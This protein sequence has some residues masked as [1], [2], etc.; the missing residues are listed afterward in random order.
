MGVS[1]PRLVHEGLHRVA[2]TVLRRRNREV[3][4]WAL[5]ATR[6]LPRGTFLGFFAGEVSTEAR[7]SLYA[8]TVGHVHIYPFADEARITPAE[9]ARRP[10]ASMNEPAEGDT[11]NCF[12]VV[13]DLLPDEVLGPAGARLYRGLACFTCRDV[14][15]DE[16]LTWHYGA[17]YE[18]HRRRQGYVAGAA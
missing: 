15:R 16:E 13:Q 12:M 11:A 17:S 5:V 10:L 18:P 14:A 6:D 8:A 1:V 3:T 7:E 9:R 2:S 4:E